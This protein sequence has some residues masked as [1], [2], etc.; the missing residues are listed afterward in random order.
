MAQNFLGKH[1]CHYVISIYARALINA[2]SRGFVTKVR[3]PVNFQKIR[4]SARYSEFGLWAKSKNNFLLEKRKKSL[5][6]E[7]RTNVYKRETTRLSRDNCKTSFVHRRR[8]WLARSRHSRRDD[9]GIFQAKSNF[10]EFRAE[11][12][13][14][15]AASQ[16]RIY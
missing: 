10:G 9:L 6:G 8:N 7:T 5:P 2:P 14:E 3:Q 13:F 4:Y 15:I 12:R 1:I 16:M 11:S